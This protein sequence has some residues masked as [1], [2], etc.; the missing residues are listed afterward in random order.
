MTIVVDADE[1]TLEQIKKQ[2][3]KLIYVV[4][5]IDL[6]RKRYIDK[7]LVLINV[8]MTPKT[9]EKIMQAVERLGA[10]ILSVGK[11]TMT[12]EE[13]GDENKINGLIE[14]LRPFGI[15]EVVRTGKIAIQTEEEKREEVG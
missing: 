6:T 5:V 13:T 15:I 7:E 11:Q 12:I 14:L 9:K 4:K 2:L 8:S 3:N 10:E 1:K